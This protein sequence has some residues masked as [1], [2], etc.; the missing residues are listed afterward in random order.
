M[1]V[2][3]KSLLM[4]SSQAN[5]G[6]NPLRQYQQ[7]AC[8]PSLGPL[9]TTGM[10]DCNVRFCSQDKLNDALPIVVEPRQYSCLTMS[11]S[12]GKRMCRVLQSGQ[13][14]GSDRKQAHCSQQFLCWI[15]HWMRE[16]KIDHPR[17]T[18][19]PNRCTFEW[20]TLLVCTDVQVCD[21][22]SSCHSAFTTS[23]SRTVPHHASIVYRKLC[24]VV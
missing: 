19:L 17:S 8:G 14:A 2:A 13:K 9:S 7:Q 18:V 12:A 23:R 5:L 1:L 3:W 24:S 16:C 4:T 10:Y 21:M 20:Y 11:W 15:Y 6:Q 22:V